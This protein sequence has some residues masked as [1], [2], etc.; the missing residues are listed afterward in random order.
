MRIIGGKAKGRRLRAPG[1]PTASGGLSI[2]PTPDPVREALFNI[3]GNSIEGAYLLD[4]F[5]GTGAVSVEALSRNAGRATLLESSQRALLLALANLSS[6]GFS[7]DFYR[8]LPGD[9]LS[10]LASLAESKEA[11]DFIFLDPP[12][13]SD[14]GGKALKIIAQGK[15][16]RERG[17]MIL[18]HSS[19]EKPVKDQGGLKRVDSREYGDTTLSFY[20][21]G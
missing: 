5:A 20:E 9:A 21:H 18:E 14:L 13:E 17:K 4:V 2:R 15:L 6:C 19:R 8:I 7:R 16:L 11:F 10:S 1:K 3:L 12:Y